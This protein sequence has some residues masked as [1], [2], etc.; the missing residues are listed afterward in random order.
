MA[1]MSGAWLRKKVRHP[2]AGRPPSFDQGGKCSNDDTLG[3]GLYLGG[4]SPGEY[5]ASNEFKSADFGVGSSCWK[6]EGCMSKFAIRLLTLAMFSMAL[7][8]APLVTKVHANPD[9]A[10][11]P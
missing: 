9:N 10:P 1:A 4:W 7:V 3:R 8:A 11:P 6:K 5:S 2:L